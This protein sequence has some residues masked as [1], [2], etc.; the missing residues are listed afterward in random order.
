MMSFQVEVMALLPS[1]V[2]D[3]LINSMSTGTRAAALKKKAREA[4]NE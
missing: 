2:R 1:F 4:K 3:Y